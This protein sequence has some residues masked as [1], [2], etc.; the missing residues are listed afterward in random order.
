MLGLQSPDEEFYTEPLM[1]QFGT[2]FGFY[3]EPFGAASYAK[4]SRT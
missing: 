4:F 3:M 2:I 1:D